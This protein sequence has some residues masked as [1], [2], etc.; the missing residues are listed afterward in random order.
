MNVRAIFYSLL[1][2][3]IGV[4]LVLVLE[5]KVKGTPKSVGLFFLQELRKSGQNFIAIQQIV[6]DIIQPVTKCSDIKKKIAFCRD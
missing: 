6:V 4:N 2:H 1:I 3:L 5:R